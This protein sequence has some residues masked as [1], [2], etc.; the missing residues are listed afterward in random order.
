ML[1]RPGYH[2]LSL[3][4]IAA[5]MVFVLSL[6]GAGLSPL[7]SQPGEL[8]IRISLSERSLTLLVNGEAWRTYPCAVG[9]PSTP[10]PVG[11][12]AIVHKGTDWGGGFGSRWLGFNVP[13]GIYGIH[14][15]NKPGT[16]GSAASA[17]CIRM[18]NRHI[19][20]LYRL[21]PV[22][23]RVFVIGPMANKPVQSTQRI[24]HTGKEVQQVQAALRE[25]GL[26][27]GFLDGRFGASTEAAV[28]ALQ[29]IYGLHPTGRA[30]HNV[31]VLLG[32]WR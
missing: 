15:T 28:K 3:F 2:V 9:K 22:G 1:R 32:L 26:N 29:T 4:L 5:C 8:S 24:G 30:D 11:E 31:L 18:H 6:G 19:E 14:G 27:P 10:T 21:V 13:W 12:W 7:G 16:I 25:L 17:G 20:E 23:T